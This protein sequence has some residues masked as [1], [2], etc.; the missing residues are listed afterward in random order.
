MTIDSDQERLREHEALSPMRPAF[1]LSDRAGSTIA[2]CHLM[3]AI[4]TLNL[5]DMPMSASRP[6]P[7]P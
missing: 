4:D 3:H 6:P 7:T 1:A 2:S 5:A